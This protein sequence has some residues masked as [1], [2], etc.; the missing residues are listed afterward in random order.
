MPKHVRPLSDMIPFLSYAH[1]QKAVATLLRSYRAGR[2][3]ETIGRLAREKFVDPAYHIT[4]RTALYAETHISNCRMATL[5]ALLAV[6]EVPVIQFFIDLEK[7]LH[8]S[9]QHGK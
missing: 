6:Y 9:T 4:G 5:L 3:G 1:V 7:E 8:N 2:S